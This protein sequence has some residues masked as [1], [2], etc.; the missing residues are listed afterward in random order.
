MSFAIVL[1]DMMH[2][3]L[4]ELPYWVC[5]GAPVIPYLC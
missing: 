1:F 5:Q 2:V 4:L 3:Y